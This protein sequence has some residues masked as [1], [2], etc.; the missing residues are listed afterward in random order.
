M[1]NSSSSVQLGKKRKS[2]DIT[3]KMD[4][5]IVK[6]GDS[7]YKFQRTENCPAGFYTEMP[8]VFSDDEDEVDEDDL[9]IR[10][11][12]CIND[13]SGPPCC[14]ECCLHKQIK[15]EYIGPIPNKIPENVQ[16]AWDVVQEYLEKRKDHISARMDFTGDGGLFH[17]D[18]L[19]CAY[20]QEGYK[21]IPIECFPVLP[22]LMMDVFKD[23]IKTTKGHIEDVLEIKRSLICNITGDDIDIPSKLED[24]DEPAINDLVAQLEDVQKIINLEVE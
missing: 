16:K 13:R 9:E 7:N 19:R 17:S 3:P 18:G 20:S 15:D 5:E 8:I 14:Y 1:S 2:Q 6:V 24:I 12:E 10:C 21:S 22:D 23:C 4:D 11:P